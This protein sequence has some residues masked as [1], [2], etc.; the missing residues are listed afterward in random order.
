MCSGSRAG[1]T[2]QAAS[3]GNWVLR[4]GTSCHPPP[5]GADA[6]DADVSHVGRA[7]GWHWASLPQGAGAG[8]ITHP[9]HLDE[10]DPS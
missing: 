3:K 8:A 9:G 4:E 7:N 1:A 2:V 10:K 5:A 6:V